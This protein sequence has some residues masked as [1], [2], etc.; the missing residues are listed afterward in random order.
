MTIPLKDL[1]PSVDDAP[2]EPAEIKPLGKAEQ[3][4]IVF[5]GLDLLLP[6]ATE[7]APVETNED[8]QEFAQKLGPMVSKMP[9]SSGRSNFPC[10]G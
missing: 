8:A 1:I 5:G 6:I 9:R 10:N 2:L 7:S 4:K 3:S